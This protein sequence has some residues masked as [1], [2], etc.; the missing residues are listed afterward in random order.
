MFHGFTDD[1]DWISNARALAEDLYNAG[2]NGIDYNTYYTVGYD[3]PFVIFNRTNEV[4]F[5]KH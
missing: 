1:N 3:S 2:E 5:V 4:W